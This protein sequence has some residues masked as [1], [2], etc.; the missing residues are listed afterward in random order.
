[1]H[2]LFW[3]KGIE[4]G[5]EQLKAVRKTF[6]K[7]LKASYAVFIRTTCMQCHAVQLTNQR[8]ANTGCNARKH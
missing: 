8:F 2:T 4:Q 6:S 3:H 5:G 1:M 7:F